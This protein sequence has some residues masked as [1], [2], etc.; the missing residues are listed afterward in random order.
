MLDE[1]LI[2]KQVFGYPIEKNT[3]M[4]LRDNDHLCYVRETTGE[5]I[6]KPSCIYLCKYD[7]ETNEYS[8]PHFDNDDQDNRTPIDCQDCL[9]HHERFG[10]G[11]VFTTDPISRDNIRNIRRFSTFLDRTMYVLNECVDL[12]NIMFDGIENMDVEVPLEAPV[13]LFED[14]TCYHFFE[15]GKQYW[16]ITDRRRFMEVI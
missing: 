9:V 4:L 11:Y 12:K 8:N 3:F 13:K 6:G 2:E 15:N 1:L 10:D 14:Y 7:A 16:F 5:L